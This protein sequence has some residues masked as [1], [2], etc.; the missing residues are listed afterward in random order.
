MKK[1]AHEKVRPYLMILPAMLGILV[2]TIYPVIKLI[3]LSFMNV[4][5]LDDSKTKFVGLENYQ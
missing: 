1:K 2:F 4:N 3:Q 5:M